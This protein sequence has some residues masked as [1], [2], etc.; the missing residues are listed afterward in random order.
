MEPLNEPKLGRLVNHSW[1]PNSKT[2]VIMVDGTPHLCFFAL[3]DIEIGEEI[4]YDYGVPKRKLPF[5][6]IEPDMLKVSHEIERLWLSKF[7]D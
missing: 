4:L 1:H 6:V 5:K 7:H 3:R 2:K